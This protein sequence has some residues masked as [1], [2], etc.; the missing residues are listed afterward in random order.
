MG[1]KAVSLSDIARR[2]NTTAATISRALRNDPRISEAMCRRAR[3]TA[4]A[5][6]Y[7]PDPEAQRLMTHLRATR[8]VRFIATLGL[9][10]DAETGIDL[11]RDPYTSHVI[12]GAEKRA[13]ELGYLLDEIR[14]RTEGLNPKRLTGI[15]SSRSL[16][17]L[18]V[19]PQALLRED[20]KLPLDD[21]AMVA[22]TAARPDLPLHRVSPDHFA[23]IT[24]LI[25]KLVELGHVRIG[26]LISEEMEIRQRR[27]PSSVYHWFVH[28]ARLL[29]PIP[30]LDVVREGTKLVPWFHRHQPTAVLA[31]DSWVRDLLEPVTSI[32]GATSLVIYGNRRPGFSGI[33]ELP[34]EIG[35]AAIDLLTAA[36]QRGEKGLP[37]HP[38]RMLVR[39]LFVN[40]TTTRELMKASSST[41]RRTCPAATSVPLEARSR[42]G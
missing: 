27:G 2:L 18:L 20:I 26:L 19:P 17:G 3:A 33:D 25:E 12:A 11:Y 41:R 14:V 37:V 30:P 39:G 31:P 28:Q 32:P 10:N 5:L 13:R 34:E 22:A 35:S 6:G 7:R 38:K 15:F 16:R 21:L 8:Q 9:I 42:R 40:G 36:I 23:N 29:V 1:R 24:L 4:D